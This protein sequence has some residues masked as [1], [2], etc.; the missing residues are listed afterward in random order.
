[1]SAPPTTTATAQPD[2]EP[3]FVSSV[4]VTFL[5]LVLIFVVFLVFMRHLRRATARAEEAMKL[6]REMLAEL[7]AIRAAVERDRS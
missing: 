7:R 5:P 1:M 3:S 6:Y 4:I 2:A